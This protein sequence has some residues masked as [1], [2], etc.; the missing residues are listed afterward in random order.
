MEYPFMGYGLFLADCAFF[1][2]R[3]VTLWPNWIRH[4]PPKLAIASS[5]PAGVVG[6]VLAPLTPMGFL[7]APLLFSKA[8]FES[9]RGRSKLSFHKRKLQQEANLQTQIASGPQTFCL[10]QKALLVLQR[11][12]WRHEWHSLLKGSSGSRRN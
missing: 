10:M 5:S 6:G 11:K 12:L 9:R 3:L 8:V 1:V 4:Q 7:F 2:K